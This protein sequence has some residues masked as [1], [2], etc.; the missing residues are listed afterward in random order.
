M[1]RALSVNATTN[2]DGC[3][4]YDFCAKDLCSGC[5]YHMSALGMSLVL[6][7]DQHKLFSSTSIQLV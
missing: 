2:Y 3:A 5:P 4:K 6:L 7:V 1:R